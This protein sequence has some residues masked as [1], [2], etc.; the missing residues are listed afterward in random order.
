MVYWTNVSV[1]SGA[2]LP[3]LSSMKGHEMVVVVRAISYTS[4]TVMQI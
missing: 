1:S 2:G 3:M 4:V